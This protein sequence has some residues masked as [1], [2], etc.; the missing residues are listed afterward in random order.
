MAVQ[1]SER[2][3]QSQE[4]MKVGQMYMAYSRMRK[5][6]HSF[7][8]FLSEDDQRVGLFLISLTLLVNCSF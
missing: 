8:R 5:D 7:L 2:G 1:I 4:K 6:D 3:R